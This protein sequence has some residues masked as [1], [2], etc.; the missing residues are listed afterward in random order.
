VK[1]LS[2]ALGN[3]PHTKQLK[4]RTKL[5]GVALDFADIKP[6]SRAFAP[7]VRDLKFDI[8]EIAIVTF[9]L[10]RAHGKPLVLLPVTVAARFQEAALL[11][12]A[13][14]TRITGP[15]DLPGK[16]IGVRAYSQTT[17][18]WIRGVL[19]D[20]FGISAEQVRWVTFE[21]AHV[22]EFSDPAWAERAGAGQD[23][24]AMLRGGALDAVIV[25]ND[26]P[27]DPA[28][29][30]VF[31]DP[32]AAAD[33]FRTKHGLMPVNHLI[34][35]RTSLLQARP[36]LVVEF[37]R[38]LRGSIA[39]A[40]GNRDLPMGRAAL[41]P[42]IDLALRYSIEQGLVPASMT[43]EQVWDGLPAGIS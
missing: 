26:V 20:D 9:L 17:G 42:A 35:V 16:R 28:F 19:K 38:E 22:A 34:A 13:D 7:M 6:I 10:A 40:G 23:M 14:D 5:A 31:P 11:C 24:L 18:V 32:K 36:D 41:Q 29:R 21:D 8:S 12:R 37:L 1:K 4:S 39:A 25:G 27:D 30:T 15:A 33:R 43:G 3:Y 2:V